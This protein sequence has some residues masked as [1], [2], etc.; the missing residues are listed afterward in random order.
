MF[1]YSLTNVKDAPSRIDFHWRSLVLWARRWQRIRAQHTTGLCRKGSRSAAQ[2][3]HSQPSAF[4][5]AG[6]AEGSRILKENHKVRKGIHISD[7][8]S[9]RFLTPSDST[10]PPEGISAT[11]AL[12]P[13]CGI[14]LSSSLRNA[15]RRVTTSRHKSNLRAITFASTMSALWQS[16]NKVS[17]IVSYWHFASFALFLLLLKSRVCYLPR[18]S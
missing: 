13:P 9:L 14:C 12:K 15:P 7:R 5:E 16:L 6:P 8:L 10:R 1:A 4:P 2:E 17:N 11:W 3:A 18:H